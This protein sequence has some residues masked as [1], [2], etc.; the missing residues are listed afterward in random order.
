MRWSIQPPTWAIEAS[1]CENEEVDQLIEPAGKASL[2]T[3][4]LVS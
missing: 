2:S 1:H 3:Q 4:K